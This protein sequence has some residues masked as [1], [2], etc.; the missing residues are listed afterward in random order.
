MTDALI[1]RTVLIRARRETVFSFFQ[2]AERFAHWWGSGSRIEATPGG[3]VRIVYPNGVVA[4]GEVLELTPPEHVAFT[5]GYEDPARPLAPGASRVDVWLE[6]SEEGTRL[7]LRHTFDREDVRDMHVPGWRFQLSLFA[8]V[9]ADL[10]HADLAA[11]AD[12]W[13]ALFS[14]ED[15]GKRRTVLERLTTDSVRFRDR[16][17]SLEGREELASHLAALRAHAPVA[18][19]R[20]GAVRHCQGTALVDWRSASSDGSGERGTHVLELAPG[21]RFASVV[22]L[23]AQGATGDQTGSPS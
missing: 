16:W 19:E 2:D 12:A 11:R 22:G 17:A 18:L 23:A 15:E 5:F 9:A 21:G 14:E 1:E 7:K 4:L 13:L 6:E 3:E 10:Q 8:N 20:A